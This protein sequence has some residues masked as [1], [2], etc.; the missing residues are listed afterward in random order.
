MFDVFATPRHRH[1]SLGSFRA[2]N[3]ITAEV[4]RVS[5]VAS[6]TGRGDRVLAAN[7]RAAYLAVR[8][9]LPFSPAGA[10]APGCAQ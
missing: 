5:S 3:S 8:T 10:D 1:D 4:G 2:C 7:G 9:N 6:F